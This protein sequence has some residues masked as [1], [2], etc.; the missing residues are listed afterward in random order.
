[1]S[2]LKQFDTGGSILNQKADPVGYDYESVMHYPDQGL[3]VAKKEP[4]SQ[5]TQRMGWY[6]LHD[7]GMSP[8]DKIK[9]KNLYRD[10]PK[11][12]YT[13]LCITYSICIHV[14]HINS[15]L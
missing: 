4:V 7:E 8:K 1:M 5:N 10:P 13:Y 11:R 9:L 6:Y 2:L 15:N 12:K 14:V 3:M